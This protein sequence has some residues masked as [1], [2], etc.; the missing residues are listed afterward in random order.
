MGTT[1]KCGIPRPRPGIPS[2]PI[3][4]KFMSSSWERPKIPPLPGRRGTRGACGREPLLD[5]M[6]WS[7]SR[8]AITPVRGEE[9]T[10]PLAWTEWNKMPP[11]RRLEEGGKQG[12]PERPN[13]LRRRSSLRYSER[14]LKNRSIREFR[15]LSYICIC[16][17]FF[18]PTG[19][20]SIFCTAWYMCS[21]SILGCCR[22]SVVEYAVRAARRVCL[23]R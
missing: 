16:A 10:P 7:W 18:F 3:I 5:W 8:G 1:L 9:P 14:L 23:F 6:S 19:V 15:L 11:P 13:S 21:F 22:I 2:S 4:F 20:F 12:V 17:K